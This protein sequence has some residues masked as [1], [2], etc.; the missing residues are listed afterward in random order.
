MTYVRVSGLSI[1]FPVYAVDHR[2]LKKHI[3]GAT[4]GG[5]V[6]A[7]SS[8]PP[9]I[10]ALRGVSLSLEPGD[11][12]GLIGH[13]GSGK[14]TLLRALAGAY[15]PDEGKL[16]VRGRIAS[17]LDLSLGVDPSATGLENIRL[18]AMIAGLTKRQV[19]ERMDEIAEFSGLGPY[20]AMPLK[21]YSAG[22]QARLAFSVATSVEADVVLMDEWISVG[23]ASFREASHKRLTNMV[24]A[25]SILVIASH[26]VNTI[27]SYCTKVMRLEA[28][29]ASPVVDI[30]QLDDLIAA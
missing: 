18:R 29:R 21:T 23:D 19:D 3:V 1:R 20:L 10:S 5:K 4:V 24:D 12:L 9:I 11:R 30:N 16:E 15:A 7:A 2:S 13:N 6:M 8:G 25:A 17:L 27:R 26:D 14:T 28:G 22:M